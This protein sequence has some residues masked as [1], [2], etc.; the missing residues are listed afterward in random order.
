MPQLVR[1]IYFNVKNILYCQHPVGL[2]VRNRKVPTL[3]FSKRI[4]FLNRE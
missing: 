3:L 4:E 1:I 2:C